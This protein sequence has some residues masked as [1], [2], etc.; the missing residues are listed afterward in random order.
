MTGGMW[1]DD[2]RLRPEQTVELTVAGLGPV[3]ALVLR[4]VP[5]AAE[6]APAVVPGVPPGRYL[7]GRRCRTPAG[8]GT[9]L[10]APRPD[11]SVRDDVVHLVLDPVAAAAPRYAGGAAAYTAVRP[12]APE[13]Q[14]RASERIVLERPVLVVPT[15]TGNGWI[16]ARTADLSAGGAALV[17]VPSLRAGDRLRLLLELGPGALL[18]GG[19]EVV[20]RDGDGRAG[21]RLDRLSARDRAVLD[22]YLRARQAAALA[23]LRALA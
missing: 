21:V 7:A 2:T 19:G 16:D 18:D 15:R 3:A 12:H 1:D 5:G 8:A 6:L 10:A 14:R 13:R 20:H 9:L 17:D 4:T 23:E 11:G 22:R